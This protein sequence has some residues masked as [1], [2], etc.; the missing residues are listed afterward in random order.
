MTCGE[1]AAVSL[2]IDKQYPNTDWSVT[3]RYSTRCM[4]RGYGE[5][6]RERGI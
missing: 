4:M 2:V 3:A 6:R 1:R 5:E